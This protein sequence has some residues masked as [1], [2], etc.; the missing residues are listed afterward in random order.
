MTDKPLHDSRKAG[1]LPG[2]RSPRPPES[3]R[4]GPS[5]GELGPSGLRDCTG[6][7]GNR[8]GS[9]VGSR[10]AVAIKLSVTVACLKSRMAYSAGTRQHDLVDCAARNGQARRWSREGYAKAREDQ[11]LN[12]ARQ[13][14]GALG[15]VTELVGGGCRRRFGKECHRSPAAVICTVVRRTYACDGCGCGRPKPFL[16]C[17]GSSFSEWM[18]IY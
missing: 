4:N 18:A 15:S 5:G 7:G 11:I 6:N 8:H 9:D 12:D 2:R 3:K 1:S 13:S 14:T 10:P 16:R 17:D